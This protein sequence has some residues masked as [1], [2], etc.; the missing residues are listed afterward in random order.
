MQDQNL[1]SEHLDLIYKYLSGNATDIEVKNLES[2]V[3][4]DPSN[5]AY[6]IANKKAWMLSGM[7]NDKSAINVDQ[8]WKETSKKLFNEGKV[9]A[10]KQK[11][12]RR[13]WFASAA[14]IA[15]LILSGL[16]L[17]N[18]VLGNAPLIVKANDKIKSVELPDGSLVTLNQSS[19]LTYRKSK[20]GT[21]RKVSLEGAAFFDVAR[22]ESKPFI[23]AAK[24]VEVEVLGTS[25]YI[26]AREGQNEIQVIVKSG[27][28]A[29]QSGSS[30]E[31]LKAG[32]KAVW[33]KSTG[34]LEKETN[35]DQNFTSITTNT[36]VF[37]QTK[38]EEVV[39]ALNRQ[40]NANIS[41]QNE[42]L[43]DCTLIATYT[44]K[45]L[46]AILKILEKSLRGIKVSKTNNKFIITGTTCE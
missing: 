24:G 41:I 15:L 42:A 39:F 19:T 20:E 23:I 32:E 5:K 27:S 8:I 3:L 43:K 30:K 29:V 13:L 37:N 4:A 1:H 34:I 16:W 44:N 10:L 17:F 18:E 22:D 26:D 40:F 9:V 45:S 31:I 21:Q 6:F 2:W 28:V 46:E 35:K 33:Y 7:K 38:L 14:A 36:L 25:F 12:N 11:Q